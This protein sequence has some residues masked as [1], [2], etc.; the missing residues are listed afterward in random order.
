MYIIEFSNDF[1]RDKTD[2]KERSWQIPNNSNYAAQ[3]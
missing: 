3:D 1:D 2:V